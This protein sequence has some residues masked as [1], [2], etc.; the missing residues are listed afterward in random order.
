MAHSIHLKF[1][2]CS[3]L[4]V[5]SLP[6]ILLFWLVEPFTQLQILE[7]YPQ[8]IGYNQDVF[9]YFES[10][11]VLLLPQSTIIPYVRC[12]RTHL[13]HYDVNLTYPQ[14]SVLPFIP[15]VNPTQR[16]L[17]FLSLFE[18]NSFGFLHS[19][20]RR[21][22]EIS[23]ESEVDRRDIFKRDASEFLKDRPFDQLD[24][25]VRDISVHYCVFRNVTEY[26]VSSMDAFCS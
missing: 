17:P 20:A 7:T 1:S 25:W 23:S 6:I 21:A 12:R 16:A 11:Y 14:Q 10:Q 24:P 4:Q 18:R 22:A 3:Q 19:L 9:K 13:C 15:L 26:D 8:L 5:S 2:N